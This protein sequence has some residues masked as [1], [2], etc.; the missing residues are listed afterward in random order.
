MLVVLV[1][2]EVKV[3]DKDKEDK[4]VEVNKSKRSVYNVS[5]WD[6]GMHIIYVVKGSVYNS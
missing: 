2:V 1:V 3:K 5:G 4:G 6:E